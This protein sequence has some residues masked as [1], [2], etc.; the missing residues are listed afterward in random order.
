MANNKRNIALSIVGAALL[1]SASIWFL[2]TYGKSDDKGGGSQLSYRWKQD[3]DSVNKI[4]LLHPKV[5]NRIEKFF[6]EVEKKTGYI[7]KAT[8]G[9]RDCEL[10]NQL[11]A[12]NASNPPCGSSDHNYGLAVDVNAYNNKGQQILQKSSTKQAWIDS[13][14]VKIAADN[15]LKWG[16]NF[17]TYH[18]PIHFYDDFGLST[19]QMKNLVSTGKVDSNGYI[20]I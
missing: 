10:Q 8:S 5:R 12:Q 17:R 1:V 15:G 7:L 9:L 16:G 11:H 19:T 18:D 20:K 13:K 14:I 3:Q 6:N 2:A 4:K